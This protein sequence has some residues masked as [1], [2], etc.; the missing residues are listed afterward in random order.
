MVVEYWKINEDSDQVAYLLPVL[1]D[2]LDY[3]VKA[4]FFSALDLSSGFH[5]ITMNPTSIKYTAS[6]TNERHF[7]YTRIPFGL[8]NA[9]TTF[10][11]MKDHALRGLVGKRCFAYL[12]H[13]LVFVS[14]T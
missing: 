12:D 4:K 10:Q 14:T 3:L 11:R 13:I 2:I 7:E 8:K 9:P 1:E 5:Q 6:S